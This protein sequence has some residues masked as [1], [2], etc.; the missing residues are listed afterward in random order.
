MSPFEQDV[1]TEIGITRKR[2]FTP[3]EASRAL[4]LIRR[5]VA[6]VTAG[7]SRLL[8]LHETMEAAYESGSSREAADARDEL[9]LVV[10]MLQTCMDELEDVGV[11]LKDW[12]TG[13][14]DFPCRWGGREICLCWQS[15]EETV[16]HWHETSEGFASRRSIETLPV[17]E[18]TPTAVL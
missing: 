6:D 16:S 2:Y 11:E 8:D 3:S 18:V 15:G 1:A 17:S 10:D 4:I 12:T 13:I 7:Y 14:V 9:V 5:I